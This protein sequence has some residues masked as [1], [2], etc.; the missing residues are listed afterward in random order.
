MKSQNFFRVIGV[1]VLL[2]SFISPSQPAHASASSVDELD[3]QIIDR[4]LEYWDANYIGYVNSSIYENWWLRLAEYHNFIVTVSPVAGD[5]IPLLILLDAN[6]NELTSG[7]GTITG[8]QPAGDYS[9]LVQPQI[10]EGFYFLL[11]RDVSQTQPITTTLLNP[12]SLNVSKTAVATVSLNNVP[13]EGYTSAE[14]TCLYDSAV[15]EVSNIVVSNRFGPDPSVAI[16][17]S[18]NN[19]FIVALA[20]SRGDKATTS[21][22]VFTFEIKGL[23]TGHSTIECTARV[24]KGD[25]VLVELPS[26]GSRLTILGNVP[27]PTPSPAMCNQAEFIADVNVPPGTVMV[28][29]TQFIKTWRLKN[30]GT[31]AWTTSY[32][33]VFFSGD[34]MW[35]PASAVFP[36]TVEVG[37]TVDISL[38]MTAPSMAGF[39]Q[40]NWMIKNANGAL[41]G[42]GPQANQPF[43][44]NI[45]VSGATV[46]VGSPTNTPTQSI[47]PSPS[48]TPG[49]STATPVAAVA[50]DFASNACAAS[51]FSSAGQLPCP[52]IDGDPKGFVLK[53][54][55]PVLE[56]GV[57]DT[58]PGLLTFPQNVQNGY[59]Q[60]FYPPIHVQSGD[61][62]RSILNCEGGATNCYVAF[63]LDYQV[64]SDSIKTFWGP[65]LERYDGHYYS[66]DVDV[67][68][69][70][71]K[72]VKFILTLLSAGP[73]T[74]DYAEWVN[75]IIYRSDLV[76]TASPTPTQTASQTP[77]PSSTPPTSS[78]FI[79][80]TSPN[81][82]EIL[83][84]GSTYR[85]TWSSTSDIK[86]VYIGYKWSSSG[87]DWIAP[88]IPNT[89]YYDWNVLV[90][91][92]PS[93]QFKIYIYGYGT[94]DTSDE[95]DG[96]IT[97][98][99][100]TLTDTPTMTPTASPTGMISGQVI[101]S[102]PVTISVYDQN[103]VLVV[104][105]LASLN[106]S[107][108]VTLPGG[109]YTV[110]AS[111]SGF[112]SA[113]G[114]FT[115]TSNQNSTLPTVTL[116][117]GDNDGNNV[118]DQFDALT[119]GMSYNMS[120]PAAAD[121]N[122]DG[123]INVLDLELLAQSY[124]KTGP[125]VWQ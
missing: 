109:T 70:A 39:Y 36:A 94:A 2:V 3:M 34:Q 106:N 125:V 69:L 53:L 35:A 68:S 55:N 73:A 23:Q 99:K 122:N 28:P 6:G 11:L 54:N 79:Q 40:S 123:I 38:Q 60:G 14:F 104:S 21:G 41:F 52:G 90:G 96:F 78:N 101:A 61:R 91:Q 76:A 10:G 111:A 5:L 44:V 75:P 82:G 103:N 43:S 112:L 8:A 100:P 92:M 17:E 86:T 9:I 16:N 83:T 74:G 121:L 24:S 13:V 93:N 113:Q 105:S 51:W 15:V 77:E 33:L 72:D 31:C 47:T 80:V 12:S 118:I 45:V 88:G 102:K 18:Q 66:V 58:R 110:V 7:I 98:L 32:Q 65:F 85:I 25:K 46:T 119:I 59:I 37:E 27:T 67:S 20:G 97:I 30:V 4:N 50:Y 64:G 89:G 1:M 42:I 84:E 117:A 56:T 81:G 19:S 120:A 87:M 95:S 115:V 107:F 26:I 124:R 48:N 108:G 116:L 49:G 29:G 57:T 114:S 63:R 62:F 71:G 22:A